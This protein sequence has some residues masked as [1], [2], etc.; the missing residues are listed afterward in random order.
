M[1]LFRRKKNSFVFKIFIPHPNVKHGKNEAKVFANHNL[2]VAFLKRFFKLS[3]LRYMR[4][5]GI[6]WVK[7]SSV[8]TK[9]TLFYLFIMS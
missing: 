3:L 7:I 6:K 5:R 1:G 2:K 8:S 9:R 4:N